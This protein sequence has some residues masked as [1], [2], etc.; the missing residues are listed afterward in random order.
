MEQ[1][2]QKTWL[3][4][5]KSSE[6]IIVNF[7]AT[8]ADK[9]NSN[10]S[11]KGKDKEG[12]KADPMTDLNYLKEK[13][14][15][16][17]A[18]CNTKNDLVEKHAEMV[19]EAIAGWEKA[20]VEAISL[21]QELDK[22]L[23][24]RLSGEGRLA[25]LD[26]ALKECMQ[27]LRF[28]REE[29]EQRIRDAVMK[30]SREFDKTQLILEEKLADSNRKLAQLGCENSHLSKALKVKEKLIEDLND[31]RTQSEADFKALA[32]RLEYTEKDNASLKYEIRV[33]E[34]ELEIRNEEREFN[35]RTAEASHKQHLESV[36]R[37]AK[38]E[39]ECQ[40]L[41]IL[42]RKRLPGPAAVAKMKNEVDI[43]G[44]DPS[45]M[46]RRRQSHSYSGSM[47]E[48][49]ADDAVD[50]PNKRI[51]FLTEQLHT[52]EEENKTLRDILSKKNNELQFSRV[53][54]A[55]TAS[56][57]SQAEL[58]LD[59]EQTRRGSLCSVD[60]LSEIGSDDKVSCSESW[61]SALISELEHFKSGKLVG[62][63]SDK[64]V[65]NSDINLMNDFV[66][67]EKLAIVSVDEPPESPAVSLVENGETVGS[68]EPELGEN[69]SETTA[70]EMIS[71][72]NYGSG[73]EVSNGGSQSKGISS[74]KFPSWIEEILRLIS[75]QSRATK[76][77]PEEL[78]EEV[79]K[80]LPQRSSNW[81]EFSREKNVP[82]LADSS[83]GL[84][85]INIMSMEKGNQ[86][87]Q[88]NLG[89]SICKVIELIEGINPTTADYATQDTFSGKDG[90]LF[91]YKSSETSTGY[92]VRVFQ[93]KISELSVIMK[94]FTCTCNDLINGKAD[95][96][97][98]A[99]E[100]ASALEWIL[101][102]CFSLQDVSSM[103][104]AIKKHFEW[105][106]T[107][108]EGEMEVGVISQFSNGYNN[109]LFQMED[110]HGNL[111]EEIKKLK[112]ELAN[113]ESVKKGLEERLLS[114]ID[115]TNLLTVQLGES[116]Q[117]NANLNTEI[118]TLK[119]SKRMVEDQI[120]ELKV[121]NEDLRTQLKTARVELNEAQLDLSNLEE[122]LDNKT[123]CCE[124]LEATCLELQLQLESVKKESVPN[125]EEQQLQTEMEITAASEKLAE[126][127]ATI[128]NLGKQLKALASPRDAA[129][130][131]EVIANPNDTTATITV[132]NT[133]S[134]PATTISAASP[135][136]KLTNQRF[137]LLD[138]MIAEDETRG[139]V[140]KSLKEREMS[141]HTEQ[142]TTSLDG[143]SKSSVGVNGAQD[144]SGW[145][146]GLNGINNNVDIDA[147]SALRIL[148]SKKQG[149][150]Q[151]SGGFLRKF[152]GKRKKVTARN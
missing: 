51:S 30:A 70:K 89:K 91:P 88:S 27:H 39:S 105:D 148:P 35:R 8:A 42:V 135:K 127:Q 11:I 67:M 62:T 17:I 121:V 150:K 9:L 64:T 49:A 31:Q 61:A 120:K 106:D 55:R 99:Q 45:E 102:H 96:E 101:N 92:M 152:F 59:K 72:P 52:M 103:K 36:K 130:F 94:Q 77:K 125:Q 57:L 119:G 50:S 54:H 146:A 15:S 66:E 97:K 12:I 143:N 6:N 131:D 53:M 80:A 38:L 24:Q 109:H 78:I 124:E 83:N 22:A 73:F 123:S 7:A 114:V 43:W 107:R 40:K 32:G 37:I 126:C 81:D 93:W 100:V 21:K 116:E 33:L 86:Q 98:F 2:D 85:G 113:V 16:V 134:S 46:R 44:R 34:K 108:S 79:R 139:E 82:S 56:K 115:K 122:E 47:A 63:Q 151:R 13:L 1:M 147:D 140:L 111:R 76:S 60:Q 3:W 138:Q 58:Q 104:D 118:E 5:E 128:L 48:F 18:E 136:H 26:S 149:K 25:Q 84:V 129:L 144:S 75:E 117:K 69:S 95:M 68:L 142:P 90:S 10:P 71:A 19:Q 41:R 23:Q 14:S 65:V 28:V 133:T 110:L 132:A 74:N 112:D 137:S 87:L 145:K 141:M 4:R 29:Q 20:E